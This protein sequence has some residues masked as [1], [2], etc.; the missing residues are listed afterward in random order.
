MLVLFEFVLI[1]VMD[2]WAHIYRLANDEVLVVL[3]FFEGWLGNKDALDFIVCVLCDENKISE[4]ENDKILLEKISYS[5]LK[6]FLEV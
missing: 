1:F 4:S 2:W 5:F 6:N 3:H